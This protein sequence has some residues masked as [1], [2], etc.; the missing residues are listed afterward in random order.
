MIITPRQRD[1]KVRKELT[2]PGEQIL[3]E[4]GF[5]QACSQMHDP[6]NDWFTTQPVEKWAME[7][8]LWVTLLPEL[9]ASRIWLWLSPETLGYRKTLIGSQIGSSSIETWAAL[10]PNFA[11][12]HVW[13]FNII[14]P[15]TGWEDC[16]QA[17][18]FQSLAHQM[19]S[20]LLL[21]GK[22]KKKG[23]FWEGITN[24]SF[25]LSSRIYFKRLTVA[26]VVYIWLPNLRLLKGQSC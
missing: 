14:W 8:N 6:S 25:G 17:F 23:V 15:Q 12:R 4:T 9:I 2:P 5:S 20:S 24:S 26:F 18:Y 11:I 19:S 13:N 16:F 1:D 7:I 22:E 21:D 3:M 10:W